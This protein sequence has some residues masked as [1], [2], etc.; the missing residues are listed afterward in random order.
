MRGRGGG[1]DGVRAWQ[2]G[3]FMAG[4]CVAAGGMH[5]SGGRTWQGG[6]CDGCTPLP[7]QILRDTG[8]THR[9]G[10]HSCL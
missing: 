6:M 5:G 10:M 3:T 2:G 8:G 7:R 1:M 9:T 4:G